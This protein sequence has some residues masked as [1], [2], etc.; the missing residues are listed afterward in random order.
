MEKCKGQCDPK[1]PTRKDYLTVE[2]LV[3]G[4]EID[5]ADVTSLMIYNVAKRNG[6]SPDRQMVFDRVYMMFIGKKDNKRLF[7]PDDFMDD[8]PCPR[9]REI[10][11]LTGFVPLSKL[12]NTD[13]GE[14]DNPIG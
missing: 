7:Y 9:C 2:C 5:R 11:A 14:A 3:C 12:W 1:L 10:L 8:E 4:H 6:F 13:A